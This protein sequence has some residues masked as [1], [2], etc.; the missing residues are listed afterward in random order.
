MLRAN[1]VYDYNSS[2]H[3]ER[4]TKIV[5]SI[6]FIVY[7]VRFGKTMRSVVG[8]RFDDFLIGTSAKVQ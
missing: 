5:L 2:F 3:R 1:F 4:E 6:D 7:F 8:H